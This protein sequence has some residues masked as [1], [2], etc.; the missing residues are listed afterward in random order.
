MADE[1][2]YS[3]H[4]ELFMKAQSQGQPGGLPPG[5]QEVRLRREKQGRSGKTVTALFGFQASDRQCDELGKAL[6]KALGTGGTAKAGR[7]EL[8][9]D[10]LD[11]ARAALEKLGYKPRQAGG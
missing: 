11:K 6:R 9:G 3:T 7:V 1:L 8:Q 10:C 4:P 5:G 2:V